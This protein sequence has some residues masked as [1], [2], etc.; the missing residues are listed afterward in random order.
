[1]PHMTSPFG[2]QSRVHCEQVNGSELGTRT[3][4]ASVLHTEHFGPDR[5]ASMSHKH[6]LGACA[7]HTV[8][9]V[10][11]RHVAPTVPEMSHCSPS[12]QGLHTSP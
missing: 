1:M 2:P 8:L 3:H 9:G 12:M 4:L 6:V 10:V 5:P 11:L 7:S